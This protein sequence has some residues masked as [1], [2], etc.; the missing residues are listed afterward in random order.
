MAIIKITAYHD[1]EVEPVMHDVNSV[2]IRNAGGHR[3]R[4]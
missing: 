4:P 1:I 2:G 3:E